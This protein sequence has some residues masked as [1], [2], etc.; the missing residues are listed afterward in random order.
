VQG[1]GVEGDVLEAKGRAAGVGVGGIGVFTGTTEE[2][3]TDQ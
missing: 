2:K 3:E 1:A